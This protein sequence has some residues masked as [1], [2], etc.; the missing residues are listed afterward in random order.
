M[1]SSHLSCN[2]ILFPF[3]KKKVFILFIYLPVQG[4]TNSCSTWEFQ[5]SFRLLVVARGIFSCDMWD[6]VP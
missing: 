5:S 4:L 6:L 2:L 1:D 3:I